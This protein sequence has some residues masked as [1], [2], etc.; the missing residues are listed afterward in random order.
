MKRRRRSVV[1]FTMV[2]AGWGGQKGDCENRKRQRAVGVKCDF[3]IKGA[4]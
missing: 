4:I 2:T 1:N 3:R